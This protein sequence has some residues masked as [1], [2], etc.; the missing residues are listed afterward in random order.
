MTNN[1][2]ATN[3]IQTWNA[4]FR[5]HFKETY[6]KKVRISTPNTDG[7]YK[8][9]M[10]EKK[11]GVTLSFKF[12]DNTLYFTEFNSTSGLGKF[13]KR[14][15]HYAMEYVLGLAKALSAEKIMLCSNA[16]NSSDKKIISH[17]LFVEREIETWDDYDFEL[18]IGD[19]AVFLLLSCK[20]KLE[21]LALETKKKEVSFEFTEVDYFFDF[22]FQLYFKGVET[23]VYLQ[24]KS[25]NI[26][27]K[28]NGSISYDLTNAEELEE[29]FP[30]FLEDV[31]HHGKFLSLL[32]PQS[33]IFNSFAKQKLRIQDERKDELFSILTEKKPV[34]D[35]D[36][37][38]ENRNY[39]IIQTH[40]Y[41]HNHTILLRID[42]D[43]FVITEEKVCQFETKQEGI[44]R[45]KEIVL[46]IQKE[47]LEEILLEF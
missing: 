16:Y 44:T 7:I 35:I 42:E 30:L 19:G 11:Y 39:S 29:K 45:Y 25:G 38:I 5:K 23:H 8:I 43:I 3:I 24:N 18:N 20:R 1:A 9:I 26:K 37:S 27:L 47:E 34:E 15:V 4:K 14:R 32:Q 13:C 41:T 33:K 10:E 40:I 36:V 22:C 17:Y 21:E 46:Q 28:S 31:Y 12:V 6:E 2:S